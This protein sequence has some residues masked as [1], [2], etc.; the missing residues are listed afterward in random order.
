MKTVIHPRIQRSTLTLLDNIVYSHAKQPDG[1]ILDLKLSILL[2]HGNQEMRLA[3]G[4][5]TDAP[6]E[7]LPAIIWVPGG[8]WRGTDKNQSI[9]ELQFLAER[10]FALVSMYYRS[11]A[12]AHYPAQLI[13][14]KAAVRFLRAHAE[15][16]HIDPNRIG[17]IGR[18]AGGYLAS[19][20]A[21]NNDLGESEEWSGYSSDIQACC[22]LFGPVDLSQ[23]L[24][25]T[26]AEVN[27]GHSRWSSIKKSHEG[28]LLGGSE[29]TLPKRAYEASPI[30][31]INRA[32]CP[33]A[34]FHGDQDPIVPLKISEDF[35]DAI[36]SAGMENQA[37]FYEVTGAGHGTR[38]FFQDSTKQL[39]ADFFA[40]KLS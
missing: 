7:P 31:Y 8:A 13:D 20:A 18:S 16:Y 36:V 32:M 4:L 11:S 5:T 23:L 2:H 26:T 14:V 30:H 35:Y 19:M 39:I 27:S 33:I 34:I 17:M 3:S 25:K 22:D 40:R 29:E 21:M 12:Q 1:S 38:E 6:A 28:A 24:Q 15:Q 10:G 37:E 9:A